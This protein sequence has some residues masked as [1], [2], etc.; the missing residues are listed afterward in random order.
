MFLGLHIIKSLDHSQVELIWVIGY[1]GIEGKEKANECSVSGSSL[2]KSM[3]CNDMFQLLQQQH[4][5]S[6]DCCRNIKFKNENSII[7]RMSEC[8]VIF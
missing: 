5:N 6:F 1:Q 4:P 3:A 2:D 8:R 7:G